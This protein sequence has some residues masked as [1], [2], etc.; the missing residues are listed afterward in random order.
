MPT[1]PAKKIQ[2]SQQSRFDSPK[3]A[4]STSTKMGSTMKVQRIEFDEFS[5]ERMGKNPFGVKFKLRLKMI[6]KNIMTSHTLN[7]VY[8]S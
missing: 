5:I 6:E 7:F 2:N 1:R 3:T 4:R 8:G